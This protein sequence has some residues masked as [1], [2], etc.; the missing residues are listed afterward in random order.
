MLVIQSLSL[1][2]KGKSKDNGSER[3]IDEEAQTKFIKSTKRK[4]SISQ[5]FAAFTIAVV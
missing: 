1:S 2:R 3:Q 5:F 4:S